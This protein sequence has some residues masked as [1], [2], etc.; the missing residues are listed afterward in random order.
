MV[1]HFCLSQQGQKKTSLEV[2]I[3]GWSKFVGI[4]EA[5]KSTEVQGA[6]ASFDLIHGPD[7]IR[8]LGKFTLL[9]S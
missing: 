5:L 8:D 1:L 4:S 3:W 9:D 6:E 7:Q 2:W